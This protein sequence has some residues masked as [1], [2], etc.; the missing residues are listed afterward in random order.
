[1]GY[2][3]AG[4]VVA[5]GAGVTAFSAGD[6][7]A[8]AGAGKANHAEYVVVQ[9]NLAARVPEGLDLKSA[10]FTTLGAIAL[11]GV[12]RANAELGSVVAV[13]GLGLLG[14][15][16]VKLL[17]ASGCTVIGYDPDRGRCE[18]EADNGSVFLTPSVDVFQDRVA[19][20][21]SSEGVDAV[22]IAAASSSDEPAKLAVSVARRRGVIS[23]LGD[24][25]LSFERAEFYRKELDVH[26]STSYGPGRYDPNYEARGIDYPKA[27]VPWTAGRNMQAFL[28]LAA[29]GSIDVASL[30]DREVEL[31]SAPSVY[32]GMVASA[33]QPVG[34]LIKYPDS[35]DVDTAVGE[36]LQLSGHKASRDGAVGWALVG[37]GAF[38]VSTLY[39]A[40][41]SAETKAQCLAV[42]SNDSVRGGNFA[43][44]EGI[45]NLCSTID[46]A[47]QI[48]DVEAVVLATRHDQHLDQVLKALTAGKHVFVEKPLA[49]SWG[50]L[51]AF[52]S[53]LEGRTRSE[54]VMVDFNR[55][56]SPAIRALK[57]CLMDRR[58]PL[59]A[60][61]RVNAGFINP[62][63]WIQSAEGAGRNIGEACHMYD[64]LR[65][66]AGAPPS[67]V[68][69]S[70]VG[71]ESER[72]L[73]NDNFA[74]VINFE[75]GSIGNV[76]YTATGPKSGL[77]KERLEVFCDGEAYILDDYVA[78]TRCS[79]S[80]VIW[81][82]TQDK[83]HKGAVEAFLAAV[84]GSEPAPVPVEE[85][86]EVTALALQVEDCLFGRRNLTGDD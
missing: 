35:R 56:F 33:S 51:S 43:R 53:M 1:M 69:A 55:R 50:Q 44:A 60:T 64:T 37:A 41:E 21:T 26:M 66:L 24:V 25:R 29:Q 34:V 61:Y 75:D 73:R 83:G 42:V 9:Q 16:A 15:L 31:E 2:S 59:V 71:D 54:V 38:G 19:A 11:Q 7:V 72:Y 80:R 58:G 76:V 85:Y 49:I 48:D 57:E 78:L 4:E 6:L 77:P 81:R 20:V 14:Q 63:H 74:S 22:I 32:A 10:A 45:A 86:I 3:C 36:T 68:T 40:F 5:V 18:A 46:A 13:I 27:Y 8:C 67:S 70:S 30:I 79:D 52:C 12:R 65:Y 62:A 84:S 39:P 17:A 28:N 23:I 82:G 47:L